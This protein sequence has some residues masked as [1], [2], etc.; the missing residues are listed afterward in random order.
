MLKNTSY[1]LYISL[2]TYNSSFFD[3][4]KNLSNILLGFNFKYIELTPTTGE[5]Y[6]SAR[7]NKK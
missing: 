2:R 1:E 7:V 5:I 3:I 4:I 6:L